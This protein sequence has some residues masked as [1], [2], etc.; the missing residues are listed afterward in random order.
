MFVCHLRPRNIFKW[1][2]LSVSTALKYNQCFWHQS[3]II[4]L[5]FTMCLKVVDYR[6]QNWIIRCWDG[7]VTD[8][9][10]KHVTRC[11]IYC[12]NS[13][14]VSF[15]QQLFLH[16]LY[17]IWT[18]WKVKSHQTCIA[19]TGRTPLVSKRSHSVCKLLRKWQS[20]DLFAQCSTQPDLQRIC[21]NFRF[22]YVAPSIFS[23]ASRCL[24]PRT[25]WWYDGGFLVGDIDCSVLL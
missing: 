25:M 18:V 7:T 23:K 17:K 16:Q 5:L 3:E 20:Q 1:I 15:V 10:T 21:W 14:L 24:M 11:W 19:G 2:Y 4:T 6:F 12:V 22:L 9:S 13:C 8:T